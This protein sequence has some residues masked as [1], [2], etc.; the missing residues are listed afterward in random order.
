M[1]IALDAMGGDFAPKNEVAGAL[2]ALKA[3]PDIHI[4]LVGQKDKLEAEL[5]L[6][7]AN[8]KNLAR[9]TLMHASEVV[10]MNDHPAQS[11][12]EKKDSSLAVGMKMLQNK[13][14]DGFVSSGNTGAVLA[15]SI[16]KVGRIKGVERPAIVAVFPTVGKPLV[17]LDLGA[18]V[19]CR[20]E[21]LLQFAQMGSVFAKQR[22]GVK[23]PIV[24]LLNIGEEE[25]KGNELTLESYQ[26]FK[27]CKNINFQGNIEPK[28]ILDGKIDVVVC[29]G[30]VGNVVLKLGEGLVGTLFSLIKGA[31]IKNPIAL[32]GGMLMR[33]AL[34]GI[35]KNFDYDEFGGT[36]LLGV[37]EIVIIAHGAASPRALR[38]AILEAQELKGDRVVESIEEI[39][40]TSVLLPSKK[41]NDKK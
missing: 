37:K 1:R 10:T 5:K 26:L 25:Q 8:Q 2:E 20:P 21:H 35:K 39:I 34:K 17:T 28:H 31:I 41:N 40:Q 36:L 7:K 18:N 24:K 15:A 14:V 4:V 3:D 30:F 13:E 38:N 23:N 32:L 16:F 12:R 19:D 9:I 29:D 11:F 27:E 33:P 6:Q 22:L